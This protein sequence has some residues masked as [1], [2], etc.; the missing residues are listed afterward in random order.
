MNFKSYTTW[1]KYEANFDEELRTWLNA[2]STEEIKL[3][4]GEDLK[5]GTA[6]LRGQL[7]PGN[8]RLNTYTIRRATIAFARYLKTIYSPEALKTRGVII[9]HDNRKWSALFTFQAAAV[10]AHYQIKTTL[11]P[12]NEVTPTPVVSFAVK[13]YNHVGGIVIT[14]SHNPSQYNGYKVYNNHGSQL[15]PT[16]TDQ[17]AKIYNEIGVEVFTQKFPCQSPL[18]CEISEKYYDDYFKILYSLPFNGK[19]S[20]KIHIIFSNLNGAGRNWTPVVLWHQ[21]YV[22]DVV[23]E[24]HDYDANFTT[25]PSPNPEI[26]ANFDLAIKLAKEKNAQLILLNDPDADRMG[27]A[28]RHNNKYRIINGNETAALIF[29]YLLT[30]LQAEG[31]LPAKGLVISTFVSS[32]LIDKIALD[33]N[34]TVK[35]GL[36]GFKWIANLMELNQS[37]DFLFGYEEA[38]GYLLNP[39]V[40]DKDGIQA[41]IFMADLCNY[42][43]HQGKT[44]V[45]VLED[46][47]QKYGY[48]FSYTF[49]HEIMDSDSTAKIKAYLKILRN[50]DLSCFKNLKCVKKEDYSLG[51]YEMPPQDLLKFYFENRS[52]VAVRGSGT[53]PKIKFYYD[54]QGNT[55]NEAQDHQLLIEKDL[56][57]I[58]GLIDDVNQPN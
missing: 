32:S 35:R 52:W 4:F 6:G 21:G 20:K 56:N 30:Q 3:S 11:F 57:Q 48:F 41:S 38:I 37:L 24:Q 13:K 9:G 5:F 28:V 16:A 47:Y 51:L 27:V 31:R 25:C 45:T 34:V 8:R 58:L 18:I 14:S 33:Y 42:Y 54:C 17:I 15:L 39:A 49:S 50:L 7:G 10:L 53:E 2:L 40:H 12:N 29:Y 22:V 26:H 44:L 43:Y 36:T 19:L 46:I 55:W 1:K 23:P